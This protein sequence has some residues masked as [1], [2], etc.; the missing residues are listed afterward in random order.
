MDHLA[1]KG[2]DAETV[3][4]FLRHADR[5]GQTFRYD[6]PAEQVQND[7]FVLFIGFYKVGSNAD[8]AGVVLRSVV[9]PAAADGIQRQ[10]GRTAGITAL[11]HLDGKAGVLLGID[12]NILAGV[13]ESRLDG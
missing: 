2:H 9:H 6:G 13:P 1:V 3:S 10:E 11:K 12:N 5:I 7:L 4:T 8:E